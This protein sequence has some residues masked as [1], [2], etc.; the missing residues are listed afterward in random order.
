[1]LWTASTQVRT[2]T[3]TH[4][5]EV[6]ELVICWSDVGVLR[7]QDREVSFRAGR[8]ILIGPNVPHRYVLPDGA[9]ADLRIL[10]MTLHDVATCLSP[11]QCATVDFMR[12]LGVRHADW[13]AESLDL[14]ALVGLIPDGY[15]IHDR[16]L[17]QTAWAAIALILARMARDLDVPADMSGLRH[18]KRVGAVRAWIDDHLDDE[19]G[20]DAMADR[21]GMSRSLL[22]REFRRHTG[23]SLVEYRNLR[24][25]ECSAASLAA[26]RSSVAQAAYASGFATMSQFHRQFKAVY[27]LTPAAFRRRVLDPARA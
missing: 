25:I 8:T 26:G 2:S 17:L 22:S 7:L 3:P 14:R 12:T 15:G 18:K 24:R 20:L 16:A 27:G 19:L 6:F 23:K 21:F 9:T 5:H 10:C 4:S 13:E 1:M 11:G